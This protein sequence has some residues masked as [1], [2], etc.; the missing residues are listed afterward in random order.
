M[1]RLVQWIILA[2]LSTALVPAV[3]HTQPEATP[4]ERATLDH[5]ARQLF[6]AGETAFAS[7]RYESAL[8]YFT[9]AYELSGRAV[10]LYN[11]G[12]AAEL[13]RQDERALEA[14]RGFLELVPASE[15][16]T[17]VQTRVRELEARVASRTEAQAADEASSGVGMGDASEDAASDPPAPATRSE[18]RKPTLGWALFAT[19][20]VVTATG[21]VLGALA[22][23]D[24][25]AV[26]NAPQGSSWSDVRGASTR[27]EPLSVTSLVALGVGV[28]GMGVGLVLAL[29]ARRG[30][31]DFALRVG[32]GSLALTGSFR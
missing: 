21:A 31:H 23:A 9:R 25:S 8:D 2:C 11:V 13:A 3:G 16:R 30:N 20:A 17:R 6:N 26:E 32:P 24:I 12:L 22:L 18:G 14:Y 5:E 7:G 27:A 29:T 19:G 1:R 28:V 10:L 15:Q 4:D